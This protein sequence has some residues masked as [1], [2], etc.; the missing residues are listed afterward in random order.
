MRQR[1][2]E[3]EAETRFHDTDCRLN[4]KH[5]VSNVDL[6]IYFYCIFVSGERERE[7]KSQV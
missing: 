2:R 4:C 3:R 5:A 7:V 1:K 6:E